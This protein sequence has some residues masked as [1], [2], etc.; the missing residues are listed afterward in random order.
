[1]PPRRN[2]EPNSQLPPPPRTAADARV[3]GAG[4]MD[5]RGNVR[6]GTHF[7]F[8]TTPDGQL[9][10]EGERANGRPVALSLV[11]PGFLTPSRSPS[12][13]ALLPRSHHARPPEGPADEPHRGGV[14]A[15][16]HRLAVRC[17]PGAAA[18]GCGGQAKRGAGP[19]VGGQRLQV[20]RCARASGGGWWWR[21]RAL[22][23]HFVRAGSR[24]HA[25][26]QAT[27]SSIN[28]LSRTFPAA[29]A[30]GTC[31]PGSTS[32]SRGPTAAR[33]SRRPRPT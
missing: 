19:A 4:W 33:A 32:R 5:G 12:P 27:R 11:L 9:L 18:A 8:S 6:E 29:S 14:L 23:R 28:P 30:T 21:A 15:P 10:T 31:A 17:L 13:P 22:Y 7:V 3:A 24:K 25:R 1:M 16:R 20:R 2:I 26:R